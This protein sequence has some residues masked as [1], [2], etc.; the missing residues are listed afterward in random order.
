MVSVGKRETHAGG[1]PHESRDVCLCCV[2][3]L[4]RLEVRTGLLDA[5]ALVALVW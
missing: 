5:G 3:R 4:P 2:M 1:C